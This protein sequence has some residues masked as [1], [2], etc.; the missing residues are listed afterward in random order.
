MSKLRFINQNHKS[1]VFMRM[2]A[3]FYKEESKTG[4]WLIFLEVIPEA[5]VARML[6]LSSPYERPDLGVKP[7]EEELLRRLSALYFPQ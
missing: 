1:P 2:I 6:Q 7:M 4:D 5:G 3:I